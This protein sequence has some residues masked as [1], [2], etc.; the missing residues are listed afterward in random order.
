M[1]STISWFH[2]NTDKSIDSHEYIYEKP[3][4]SMMS[5]KTNRDSYIFLKYTYFKQ[6]SAM[7]CI[8]FGQSI[9]ILVQF[10]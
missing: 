9:Y 5:W 10:K 2:V 3:Q 7:K 4:H 8:P 1:F 6:F